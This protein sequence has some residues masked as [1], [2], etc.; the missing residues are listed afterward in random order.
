MTQTNEEII[1]E[2]EPVAEEPVVEDY[3]SCYVKPHSKLSR[4]VHPEDLP[5]VIK[6]AHIMYNLCYCRYGMNPGAV[7]IAHS[8]INDTDPLRFFVT[9]DKRVIINP[10]ITNQTKYPVKRVEGC[11]SWPMSLPKVMLRSHKI[12]VD[13]DEI[14]DNGEQIRYQ[15]VPLKGVEA[16]MF[17]HECDHMNAVSVYSQDEYREIPKEEVNN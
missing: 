12:T 10:V 17:Q 6:D 2:V 11:M 14:N 7:A 4:V 16:Q 1:S 13:Y 5:K 3:T 9:A 8:Q 15:N